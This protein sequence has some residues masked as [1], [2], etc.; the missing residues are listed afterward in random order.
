MIM[1]QTHI[2]L[3]TGFGDG[4]DDGTDELLA[5]T[6]I[7]VGTN[8]TSKVPGCPAERGDLDPTRVIELIDASI[9]RT[10]QRLV[11]IGHSVGGLFAWGTAVI[12]RGMEGMEHLFLLDAPLRSDTD[13]EQPNHR[14]FGGI[15]DLYRHQYNQRPDFA[16]ACEVATRRMPEH[17]RARIT[18]IGS[19]HDQIVPSQSKRLDDIRHIEL[20]QPG[21]SLKRKIGPVAT[22]IRNVLSPTCVE[23]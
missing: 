5:Q 20:T 8:S 14:I 16:R 7:E 9:P 12:G 11:V 19:P 13:V 15:F 23:A 3:V 10:H 21:H 1:E 6:A 4:I 22:A 18:T 17:L 2:C